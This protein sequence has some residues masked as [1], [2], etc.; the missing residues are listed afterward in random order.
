MILPSFALV[1]KQ[2]MDNTK[3][4]S[5][6]EKY[7]KK[8]FS[9]EA[10]GHDHFH[11]FRVRDKA[12]RICESVPEADPVTVELGALLHDVGDYKLFDE[13]PRK[14][15]GDF[16]SGAGCPNDL[17]EKVISIAE[18]VSFK[19]SEVDEKMSSI[20]GEVVQDADRLDALGAVGIARTFA[21]GGRKK[22]PIYDPDIEPEKH[23]SFKEYKKSESPT[24]NHFY[25]KLLL[26]KDRMNTE[27]GRRMAEEAHQFMLDFLDRFYREW[28]GEY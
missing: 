16:L 15:I 12:L 20:E 17:A 1:K 13:S 26:L 7:I 11:I 8:Q 3:L 25:E 10:T 18:E 2:S 4:I 27:P 24:I 19:G 5:E 28:K 23:S 21:Y 9:G 22:R 14:L 6:T